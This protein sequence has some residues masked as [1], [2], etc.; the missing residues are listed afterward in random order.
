V[1]VLFFCNLLPRKSGSFERF[2]A[3]LAE[4]FRQGDDT[5]IFAFA[6]EP[7]APVAEAIV[8][9]GAQWDVISGWSDGFTEHPWRFCGPALELLRRHRPDV[10][11]VHFGNEIPSLAVSL[12]APIF[13]RRGVKWVWQQDQ[14]IS[15]PSALTSRLSRI[16]LLSLRFDRYIAVYE[17][18]RQSL[19]A[20]GIPAC[21]TAV[22][23][24]S[25][26]DYTPRR[27]RGWLRQETAIPRDAT[28][29]A[30]VGSLVKRKR[31]DFLMGAMRRL[32]ADIHL[33][34]AGDG[35][36]GEA[37]RRQ[38]EETGLNDRVHFLGLRDDVREVVSDADIYVHASTAET[39]TYATTESMC[40]GKPA[41]VTEAGAACE[42][43]RDGV[44]GYV[45]D[46]GDME[47]FAARVL[48]LARDP[49][50]REAMGGE[51]RR[52]WDAMLRVE[53]QAAGY[54][55]LYRSVAGL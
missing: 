55:S 32:P 54:H 45:V 6:G 25:V 24:N 53:T 21:R 34:V 11:A 15:P 52:R 40:A 41:V 31:H 42:Q 16:R 50:K 35:P 47:G 27:G 38:C 1:K 2:L 9:A 23:R 19:V 51:A 33:V 5:L 17:G 43:I 26:A 3:E 12:L 10:A 14:Q 7:V 28:V 20:R 39:C 36:M 18:G 29:L 44:S 37:L 46:P 8:S 49:A 22:I 4:R 48:E 13:G 30:T